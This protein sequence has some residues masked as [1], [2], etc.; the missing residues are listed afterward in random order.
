MLSTNGN[1]IVYAHIFSYALPQDSPFSI[2]HPII[3]S[4]L[5]PNPYSRPTIQDLSE[6]VADLNLALNI[7]LYVP[8]VSPASQSQSITASPTPNISSNNQSSLA[9][10]SLLLA[11]QLK[12][13]GISLL[14]N[15]QQRPIASSG[16]FF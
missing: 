6:Q 1:I 2:F 12:D 5:Q 13:Q 16:L 14:R 11:N 10:N 4:T 9:T 7:D 8:V 3:T 15:F